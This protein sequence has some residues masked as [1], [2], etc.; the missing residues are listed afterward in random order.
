M[1]TSDGHA[2]QAS[3]TWLVCVRGDGD[4]A[5]AFRRQLER[6][7]ADGG[8]DVLAVGWGPPDPTEDLL[9]DLAGRHPRLRVLLHARRVS[10]TEALCAAVAAT[11]SPWIL[12]P[13]PDAAPASPTS[14]PPSP[15]VAWVDLDTGSALFARAAFARLPPVPGMARWLPELF[16]RAGMQVERTGTAPPATWTR[17][18]R[19]ALL[20][21]MATLAAP[22]ASRA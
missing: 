22:A 8:R 16:A 19:I 10:H 6:L 21:T 4:R 11:R 17:H 12:L 7:C 3:T 18:A 14:V 5:P 2:R 20:C 13:G 9:R 15:D 1:E